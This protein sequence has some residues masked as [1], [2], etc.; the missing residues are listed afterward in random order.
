MKLDERALEKLVPGSRATWTKGQIVWTPPAG[1]HILSGKKQRG[2]GGQSE[3]QEPLFAVEVPLWLKGSPSSQ[4]HIV[5]NKDGIRFRA[6][7]WRLSHC[8]FRD[9]GEDAVTSMAGSGRIDDCTF[10]GSAKN[11]KCLQLNVAADVIITRCKFFHFITGI[12]CGL[13][14]YA[15]TGDITEIYDCEF[16]DVQAPIKAI[17]GIVYEAGN[18]F[19]DYKA[20]VVDNGGRIRHRRR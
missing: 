16:D 3:G 8:H 17:K 9:I 14:K 11:D 13:S 15:Q 20:N 10:Q 19:N 5:D 4:W 12:Q 2:D 18:T 1:G 6:P 7:G